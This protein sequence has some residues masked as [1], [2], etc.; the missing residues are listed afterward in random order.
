MVPHAGQKKKRAM[1]PLPPARTYGVLWPSTVT[2]PAGNR[3]CTANALPLRRWQSRQ[4][5]IE[6]RTGSPPARRVSCPQLQLA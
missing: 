2:L 5:Q 6:T 3:A 4:W 1:R